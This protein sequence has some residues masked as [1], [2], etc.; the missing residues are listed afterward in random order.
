M[1]RPSRKVY[2]NELIYSRAKATLELTKTTK[3]YTGH[4]DVD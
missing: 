2:F 3:K 4:I 1:E